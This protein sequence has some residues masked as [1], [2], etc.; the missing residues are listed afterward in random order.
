MDVL[1]INVA[2]LRLASLQQDPFAMTRTNLAAKNVNLHHPHKFVE[3]VEM[4]SVILLNFVLEPHR[5]AQKTSW[6]QTAHHV[7]GIV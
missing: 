4:K 2:T 5:H 7:V 1:V 6:Y 3:K